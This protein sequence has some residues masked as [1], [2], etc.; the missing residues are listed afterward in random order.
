MHQGIYGDL[1]PR[2]NHQPTNTPDL[3]TTTD[4]PVTI[5]RDPPSVQFG[6]KGSARVYVHMTG[7]GLSPHAAE[8][9]R[10]TGPVY[11]AVTG[12]EPVTP[13]CGGGTTA[14]RGRWSTGAPRFGMVRPGSSVAA[15]ASRP[16]GREGFVTPGRGGNRTPRPPWGQARSLVAPMCRPRPRTW[17]GAGPPRR[18]RAR[19]T[20]P[21]NQTEGDP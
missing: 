13:D 5:V 11:G 21:P 2:R 8:Q 1:Q 12:R 14:A 9:V 4:P 18:G 6:K 15:T 7:L 19:R 17:V 20:S 10:S 16:T 3:A